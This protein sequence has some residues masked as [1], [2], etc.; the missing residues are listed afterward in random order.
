ML[1]IISYTAVCVW[2]FRN[3]IVVLFFKHLRWANRRWASIDKVAKRI[4]KE[5][6]NMAN[7]I[8]LWQGKPNTIM[9]GQTKYYYDRANQIQLW[10]GK[11]NTV[12]TGQT[13]YY[14]DRANQILLWSLMRLLPR[15]R[16]GL[17]FTKKKQ[18]LQGPH[19]FSYIT[20]KSTS[21]LI[22]QWHRSASEV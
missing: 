22:W 11:P 20:F 5:S 21:P 1:C 6:R 14:Y 7:R 17:D 19:I 4:E 12:M 3:G 13:K 9:T 8:L 2:L 10:Q 18:I 15:A 16:Y